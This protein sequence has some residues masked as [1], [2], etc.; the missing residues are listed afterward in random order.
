HFFHRACV[1]HWLETSQA[2]PICRANIVNILT[3]TP[4]DPTLLPVDHRD[5]ELQ[6]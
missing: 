4:S 1:E 6:I 3:G 2:C 5:L